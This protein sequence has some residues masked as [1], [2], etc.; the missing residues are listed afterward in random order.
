M[1]KFSKITDQNFGEYIIHLIE[2]H[3]YI[4]AIY[5]ISEIKYNGTKVGKDAGLYYEVYKKYLFNCDNNIKI[6][7]DFDKNIYSKNKVIFNKV[8]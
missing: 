1:G 7:N 6:N 2:K 8:H 3:N 4:D 5:H